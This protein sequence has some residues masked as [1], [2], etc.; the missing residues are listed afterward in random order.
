MARYYCVHYHLPW[1]DFD[2]IVQEVAIA[3][4]RDKKPFGAVIDYMRR[5]R[6]DRI[7]YKAGVR[8][9][10]ESSLP[11][12]WIPD[13]EDSSA[14]LDDYV[15]LS[16]LSEKDVELAASLELGTPEVSEYLGRDVSECRLS[17]VKRVKRDAITRL[18]FGTV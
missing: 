10:C 11:S 5:S 1:S 18:Y 3:I 14:S 17:Q 7:A 2:D 4:W 15:F 8:L 9:W 12:G 16:R 6:I 13:R